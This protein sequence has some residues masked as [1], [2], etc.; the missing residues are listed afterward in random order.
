[1]PQATITSL[2]F[3]CARQYHESAQKD[4]GFCLWCESGNFIDFNCYFNKLSCAQN[5]GIPEIILWGWA[6]VHLWAMMPMVVSIEYSL[7]FLLVRR[8]LGFKSGKMAGMDRYGKSG[9]FINFNCYITTLSCVQKIELSEIIVPGQGS[10]EKRAKV[11]RGLYLLDIILIFL[12]V[13]PGVVY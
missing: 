4:K 1:L 5:S 6:C 2:I 3:Y 12:I 11:H 7:F 10:M 8:Q 13:M 9:N